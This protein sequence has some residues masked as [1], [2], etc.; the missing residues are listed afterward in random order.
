MKKSKEEMDA[1]YLNRPDISTCHRCGSHEH[2]WHQWEG[3]GDECKVVA[4]MCT[5]CL[6]RCGKTNIFQV[7]ACKRKEALLKREGTKRK[8]RRYGEK[9]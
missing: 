4:S 6:W 3:E 5:K 8:D 2:I 1:E 9:E 7:I